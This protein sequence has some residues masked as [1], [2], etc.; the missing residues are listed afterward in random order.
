MVNG[1]IG[2]I[3]N[4]ELVCQNNITGMFVSQ[5]G[6]I[7]RG[8]NH[9]GT[10]IGDV[11]VEFNG[12]LACSISDLWTENPAIGVLLTSGRGI[13]IGG[14]WLH[15]GVGKALS[16]ADDAVTY[17][18]RTIYGTANA[19]NMLIEDVQRAI[20]LYP[21]GAAN[22]ALVC[23]DVHGVFSG[24]TVSGDTSAPVLASRVSVSKSAAYAV[25]YIDSTVYVNSSAASRTMSLPAAAGWAGLTFTF[26]HQFGANT[27]TIDTT[28]TETIDGAA[29]ITVPPGGCT[30]IVSDGLNYQLVSERA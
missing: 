11:A 29:S 28:G 4:V 20:N 5:S 14:T 15:A 10:G 23:T 13:T 16:V 25:R 26:H 8:L 7:V 19:A 9:S 2:Y 21:N 3:D 30:V 18:V 27:C 24:W 22:Q 12:A 1:Q 6:M 17:S